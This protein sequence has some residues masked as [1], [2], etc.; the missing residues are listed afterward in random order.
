MEYLGFPKWKITIGKCVTMLMT[1][2]LE[3]VSDDFALTYYAVFIKPSI[4][5]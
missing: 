2:T 4:H 3:T 1:T 5:L